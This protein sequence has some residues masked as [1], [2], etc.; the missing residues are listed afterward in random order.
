MGK[1]KTTAEY[2]QKKKN[3]MVLQINNIS[4]LKGREENNQPN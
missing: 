1:M 4:T 3:L 2:K